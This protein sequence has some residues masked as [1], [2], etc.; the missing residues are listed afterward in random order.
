MKFSRVAAGAAVLLASTAAMAGEWTGN[1]GAT[2][3][4]MFRGLDQTGGAAV[5]GG[6]DYASGS[7][8][9]GGLWVS[10]SVAGFGNEADVYA[11]YDLKLGEFSLG[12][13]AIY[14]AYTE[15]TEVPATPNI[16]YAEVFVGAGIGPLALKVFYAPAFGRDQGGGV[17]GD[18]DKNELMYVTA[19]ATLVLTGT[20]SLVPQVGFSSGD[21][22]KDAFG[23]EYIDYSLTAAKSLK[24]DLSASLAV[25]G[26]NREL[27]VGSDNRDNPKFVVSFRKNFDI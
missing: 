9:Y 25:V 7:G 23:E 17:S 26:S 19:S 13:G 14:Y 20:V 21:G 22:V 1:A 11:G 27:P 12:A 15:D 24:D 6:V 16:D 3:D 10:N 5:Q 4:Y 2:S 8:P 18:P